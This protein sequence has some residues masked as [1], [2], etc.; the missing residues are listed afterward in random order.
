MNKPYRLSK[1]V[2]AHRI[3]EP[4]MRA[5]GMTEVDIENTLLMADGA[6]K[7][8]AVRYEL[9]SDTHE[10]D[11]V[12]ERVK[13]KGK[14]VGWAITRSTFH[15]FQ[16]FLPRQTERKDGVFFMESVD[17]NREDLTSYLFETPVQAFLWW[18]ANRE[19]VVV[20]HRDRVRLADKI[21]D[22]EEEEEE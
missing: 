11:I 19:N 21:L 16:F 22:E 4:V 20:F 9:E 6:I 17:V 7:Y 15:L 5:I 10:S 14:A 13:Q 2:I 18:E 12:L 1:D 3:F 8:P